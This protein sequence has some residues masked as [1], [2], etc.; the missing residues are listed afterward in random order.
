[1]EDEEW[2]IDI[3]CNYLAEKVNNTTL[4][5]MNCKGF[6]NWLESDLSII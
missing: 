1:M 3:V 2:V 5:R 4:I 6:Y